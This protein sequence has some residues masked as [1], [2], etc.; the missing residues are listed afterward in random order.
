MAYGIMGWIIFLQHVNDGNV[1]CIHMRTMVPVLSIAL[2]HCINNQLVDGKQQLVDNIF[3]DDLVDH[4]EIS[5]Y[6]FH[7]CR[8]LDTICPIRRHLS[9]K[10]YSILLK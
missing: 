3:V 8:S 1:D 6:N 9:Q 10:T 5:L 7:F 2:N 4:A